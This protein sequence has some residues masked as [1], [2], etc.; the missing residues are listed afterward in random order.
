LPAY[1][2]TQ[3][4]LSHLLF[5]GLAHAV[6]DRYS[7]RKDIQPA[8]VS[9]KAICEHGMQLGDESMRTQELKR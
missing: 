6:Y 7:D 2:I 5:L 1:I 8:V 4:L 3:T 9:H